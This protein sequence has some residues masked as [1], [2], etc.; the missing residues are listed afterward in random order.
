MVCDV[1]TEFANYMKLYLPFYAT[2][3]RW[4]S[5]T[6]NFIRNYGNSGLNDF[7]WFGIVQIIKHV[8][9]SA[10][11]HFSEDICYLDDDC[12]ITKS[13][14]NASRILQ[15]RRT[16]GGLNIYPTIYVRSLLCDSIVLSKTISV[17]TF[18]Q[19]TS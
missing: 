5:V 17:L 11:D 7:V 15:F 18:I 19:N 13:I 2:S 6:E 12:D 14:K 1:P 4:L 9:R 16:W 3:L 8:A 10:Q